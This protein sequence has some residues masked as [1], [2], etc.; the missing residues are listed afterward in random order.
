MKAIIERHGGSVTLGFLHL[1]N[2][3]VIGDNPG[4]KKILEAHKQGL[5]IVDLDQ[6]TSIITNDRKT[7]QGLLLA[8]YP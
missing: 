6:I 5:L 4:Q 1:T 3:L 8:P 7:A 2:A